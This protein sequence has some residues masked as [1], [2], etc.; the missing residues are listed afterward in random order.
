MSSKLDF[1]EYLRNMEIIAQAATE[2][3]AESAERIRD[4]IGL[5]FSDDVHAE[6]ITPALIEMALTLGDPKR[7][8]STKFA[9]LRSKTKT[10]LMSFASLLSTLSVEYDQHVEFLKIKQKISSKIT[11]DF[12]PIEG[13]KITYIVDLDD[14]P[15]IHLSTIKNQY[16]EIKHEW[17]NCAIDY[18][19]LCGVSAKS[20]VS[21]A[22]MLEKTNRME[23]DL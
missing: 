6:A 8:S 7:I 3:S 19:D 11:I 20:K 4:L 21:I 15:I 2:S 10:N 18:L 22:E 23:A 14:D 5:L 13:E 1:T 17:I 9:Q 12:E 16:K